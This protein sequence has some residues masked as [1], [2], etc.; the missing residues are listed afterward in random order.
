MLT[1]CTAALSMSAGAMKPPGNV[2]G[3][4]P[5]ALLQDKASQ[6]VTMRPYTPLPQME[7]ATLAAT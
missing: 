3:L 6:A 5:L 7:V 1:L 4:D 2:V